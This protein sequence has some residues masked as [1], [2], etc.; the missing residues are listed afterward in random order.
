MRGVRVSSVAPW[1]QRTHLLSRG[2]VRQSLAAA[3]GFAPRGNAVPSNF[4]M[5]NPRTLAFDLGQSARV[6]LWKCTTRC[7]LV[8]SWI[9]SVTTQVTSAINAERGALPCSQ[10]SYPL[11]SSP[12]SPDQVA[13]LSSPAEFPTLRNRCPSERHES[14]RSQRSCTISPS[15]YAPGDRVPAGRKSLVSRQPPSHIRVALLEKSIVLI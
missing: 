11:R 9:S 6:D 15:K 10:A 4:T 7:W 3:A 14:S 8:A 1:T 12:G 5:T 13:R 2:P